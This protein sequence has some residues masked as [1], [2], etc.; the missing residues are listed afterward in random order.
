MMFPW[1]STGTLWRLLAIVAAGPS[2]DVTD[3]SSIFAAEP[4]AVSRDW[5][6]HGHVDDE[7]GLI[8][9]SEHGEVERGAAARQ[10]RAVGTEEERCRD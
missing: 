3:H 6:R 4:H 7:P 8:A 9:G 2:I 5:S 1:V 10:E